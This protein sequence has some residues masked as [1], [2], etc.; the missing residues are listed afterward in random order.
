MVEYHLAQHTDAVV[1][2][3]LTGERPLFIEGK[4]AAQRELNGRCRKR[5]P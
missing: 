4:H 3:P 2:D 1:V 5:I